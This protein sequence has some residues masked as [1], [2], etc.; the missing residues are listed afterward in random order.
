MDRREEERLRKAAWVA[1]TQLQ[2]SQLS[3]EDADDRLHEP[4][5]VLGSQAVP[6]AVS[7]DS[8]SS[9]EVSDEPSD[10]EPYRSSHVKRPSKTA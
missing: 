7:S 4:E 8:S 5:P 10:S 6:L 1:D 9:S 2:L 3:Y